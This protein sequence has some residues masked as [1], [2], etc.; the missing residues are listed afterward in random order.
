MYIFGKSDWRTF[1]RGIEREWLV[2]NGIGGYA[3]ST[4]VNANTRKYHGYLVAAHNPPGWRVVQFTK[5][6]E[7]FATPHCLYN[8]SANETRSGYKETGFIH[9]QQVKINPFPTFT[10]SFGDIVLEKTIFMLYGRNT[11]VI[12]Y[13]VINGTEPGLLTLNPL[14]NCRGYHYITSQG[15]LEFTQQLIPGGVAVKGRDD[16][17]P[18]LLTC[19]AGGFAP[20]GHWYYG[21]AYAGERERGENPYEDHY[22]PGHFDISFGP[23]EHK[24]FTVVATTVEV[25][26]AA[27]NAEELLESEKERL[28]RVVDQAG[29]DDHLARRLV[30]AADAFIV[31]RRSTGYKTVIAGYPWFTDWGRDTMISLP[32]LTLVTRRFQEAR[33]ILITYARQTNKGLLPNSFR[34]GAAE[35]IFNTVDASL[36]FVNAAYKYLVYTG[37]L[38]FVRQ[39]VYPALKDIIYWYM[40][41]TEFNIAMDEDGLMNAGSPDVQL[42]WMDAKVDGWVVTPRHGKAVE[43][44]ALWYNAVNVLKLMAGL[45]GD[46]FPCPD[47]PGKIKENF[48]SKFWLEEDG[49]LCDVISPEGVDRRLRPNQLLAVSLPYPLLTPEQGRRVVQ[50][51]W[52]ELYVTYGIRSLSPGECDYRGCYAGDRVQRDSCYHMGTSWSWLMGPFITAY[53]KSHEY[54]PASKVQALRFISPFRDQLRDHGVG[55]ISEIFDGDE[56]AIPRGCFA[57]AW[58]VAE[59]LRAYIEDVMEIRP[60][61]EAELKAKLNSGVIS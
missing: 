35:P 33:E 41:G 32:G 2:T 38:D 30:Q 50:R 17:P 16:I 59:V 27:F 53:R 34:I 58:G 1:E 49:Y 55:Y 10:Y 8:L 3:S 47:L 14:V 61:A 36:W 4:I 5:L 20:E 11:T 46:E 45:F 43:I 39:E 28:R 57:Q 60:P 15:D 12:L 56:P 44:N 19:S 7:W 31:Y 29:Y 24:T 26:Q 25:D 48:I 37:D 21:M 18:L 42:T 54:S 22:I 6:D 51:I 52:K 23:G 9:L 40:N 13:R